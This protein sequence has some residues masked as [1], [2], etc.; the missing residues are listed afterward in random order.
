[1]ILAALPI[2]LF[3]ILGPEVGADEP[4][5]LVAGLGARDPA[6]REASYDAL[7]ALGPAAL[8]ALRASDDPAIRPIVAELIDR[9]GSRRLLRGTT[10]TLDD[11]EPKLGEVIARIRDAYGFAVQWDPP[12]DP[13][14]VARP[15]AI[16][17]QGPVPFWA[18][19]EAVGQ[20]AG[21]R[22]E[23]SFR[24][25]SDPNESPLRLV[26][27]DPGS[28]G[29]VAVVGP[30]RLALAYLDRYRSVTQ[31]APPAEPAIRQVFTVGLQ[32]VPEPGIQ[33]ARN[34]PVRILDAVDDQGES[35]KPAGGTATGVQENP[36]P[37]RRWTA[38]P[39]DVLTLGFLLELPP[40]RGARIARLRGHVPITAITRTDE[41]LA[42]PLGGEGDADRVASV[43]GIRVTVRGPARAD[44]LRIAIEGEKP[45]NPQGTGEMAAGPLQTTSST[46]KPGFYLDDHLRIEDE[47]GHVFGIATSPARGLQPVNPA[48]PPA[49]LEYEIRLFP[50]ARDMGPPARLRYFG[51]AAVAAEIPFEFRDLPIP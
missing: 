13:D 22:I 19:L 24:P 7:D 16:P 21:L 6:R 41:I 30:Y 44:I 29:P 14:L 34:G 37:F 36:F 5:A 47:K 12:G 31:L 33:V 17:D 15:I 51:V 32:I 43:G 23:T 3:V 9:I 26:P 46:L 1:M 50:T 18:R 40:N 28:R 48:A 10:R 38:Q 42:I 25:G 49:V 11:K 8:P 39:L 20:A 27:A 35:L 45:A 2:V 4:A